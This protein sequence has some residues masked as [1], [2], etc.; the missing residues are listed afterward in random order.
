[1]IVGIY[2]TLG[3]FL[4]WASRKPE[5]HLSLIWFTIWSS[6]V[7]GAIMAVQAVIEPAERGHLLGD[8]PALILVAIVLGLLAP[9]KVIANAARA[10]GTAVL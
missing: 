3:I 9:R 5:A 4:L 10:Q 1:M 7:H 8:V 6:A 2:A